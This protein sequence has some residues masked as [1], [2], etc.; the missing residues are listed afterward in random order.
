MK[1]LI[2]RG[3]N[4]KAE[5]QRLH[6]FDIASVRPAAKERGRGNRLLEISLD[7]MQGCLPIVHMLSE[8]LRVVTVW[9]I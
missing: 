9:G 7:V 4:T 8:H 6:W 5:G 2:C 3:Q 1:T